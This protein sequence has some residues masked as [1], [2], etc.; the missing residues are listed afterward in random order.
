[1]TK[2]AKYERVNIIRQVKHSGSDTLLVGHVT[3][4]KMD[5]ERG[6]DMMCTVESKYK[7]GCITERI[8]TEIYLILQ[9]K[10]HDV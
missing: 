10:I 8:A 1:M 5:Q 6:A 3:M 4:W 9:S 2:S 7:S